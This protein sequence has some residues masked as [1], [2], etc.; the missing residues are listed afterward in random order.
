MIPEINLFYQ[1]TSLMNLLVFL[2]VSAKDPFL[3]A[4]YSR[5]AQI[6]FDFLLPQQNFS[7]QQLQWVEDAANRKSQYVHTAL[8]VWEVVFERMCD[9]LLLDF[10]CFK[11]TKHLPWLLKQK[12]ILLE[13]GCKRNFNKL[14]EASVKLSR[15]SKSIS[16]G[17][18]T[19]KQC[20]E[21]EKN[22]KD[23]TEL[24]EQGFAGFKEDNLLIVLAQFNSAFEMLQKKQILLV[25][26]L[27]KNCFELQE[28]QDKVNQILNNTVVLNVI[29]IEKLV[30][31]V[32]E[33]LSVLSQE[34]QELIT[35][36]ST[37]KSSLFS[38][39]INQELSRESNEEGDEEEQ[40]DATTLPLN[41]TFTLKQVDKALKETKKRL[42]YILTND[43]IKIGEISKAVELI[44]K[45]G[46]QAELKALRGFEFFQNLFQDQQ[47]LERRLKQLTNSLRFATIANSLPSICRTVE[48]NSLCEESDPLL[49]L[50]K[51]Q[52]EVESDN[53]TF[54][55][56]SRRLKEFEESFSL[57]ETQVSPFSSPFSFIFNIY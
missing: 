43:K 45:N 53:L 10:N 23:F 38:Y 56:A 54:D 20:Q 55:E 29:E 19:L 36:F 30:S 39:Y 47:S 5:F 1:K 22:I 40:V 3:L 9:Y 11:P 51:D 37:T 12:D 44:K 28:I 4:L 24:V 14:E 33:K 18:L 46:S 50:L 57:S 27:Q 8:E 2:P 7:K 25:W 21:I 42:S 49:E 41:A 15:L 32:Q 26:L 31:Q 17:S 13:K 6:L 16:E 35:H 52:S 48:S 34:S